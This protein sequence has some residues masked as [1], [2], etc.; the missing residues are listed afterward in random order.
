MDHHG[1]FQ[2]FDVNFLTHRFS[3][4]SPVCGWDPWPYS[5]M[6]WCKPL[7]RHPTYLALGHVGGWL[8]F[9]GLAQ[10][11]VGGLPEI[12]VDVN[13]CQVLEISWCR[14]LDLGVSWKRAT[15]KSFISRWG[16]SLINHPF[17]GP[18]WMETPIFFFSLFSVGS[19]CSHPT[20]ILQFQA[21]GAAAGAEIFQEQRMISSFEIPALVR[22]WKILDGAQNMNGF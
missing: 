3:K 16:L 2:L 11:M 7:P 17:W 9:L 22:S 4:A 6:M 5:V 20:L 8:K 15:A 19:G 21:R 10:K 12:M 13:M 18:S 14:L 1:V